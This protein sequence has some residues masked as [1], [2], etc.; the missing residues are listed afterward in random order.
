M[1]TWK[2]FPPHTWDTEDL[3]FLKSTTG[4]FHESSTP[5]PCPQVGS[6]AAGIPLSLRAA[7][8]K[9]RGESRWDVHLTVHGPSS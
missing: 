9:M 6:A 8:T 4:H 7:V 5:H 2:P 1:S 3:E